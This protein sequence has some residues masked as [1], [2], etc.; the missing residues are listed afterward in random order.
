MIS[1]GVGTNLLMLIDTHSIG[2]QIV[3]QG[4]PVMSSDHE[5]VILLFGIRYMSWVKYAYVR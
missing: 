3:S 5:L 2:P 1:L 4:E